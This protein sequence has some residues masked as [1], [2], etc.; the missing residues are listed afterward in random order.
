[1]NKRLK[2]M[3]N[4]SKMFQSALC[5]GVLFGVGVLLSDGSVLSR[6]HR[7]RRIV[8]GHVPDNRGK[9]RL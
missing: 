1:M 9:E 3:P 2:M 6:S 7:V 5:F 4:C 8:G